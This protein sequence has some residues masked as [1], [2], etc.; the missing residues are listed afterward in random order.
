MESKYAPLS[1]TLNG[2]GAAGEVRV[3]MMFS[4]L[5]HLVGGLP[6]SAYRHRPW[7]ANSHNNHAHSWLSAGWRVASV[8]LALQRVV[9]TVG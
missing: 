3:E 2:L 7:W 4:Q 6:A 9:F 8:D 1:N 5:D